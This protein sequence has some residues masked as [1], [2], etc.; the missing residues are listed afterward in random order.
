MAD[1]YPEDVDY[2]EED[3]WNEAVERGEWGEEDFDC[4]EDD[5]RF[6][7]DP[8]EYVA[9]DEELNLLGDLMCDDEPLDY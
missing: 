2:S 9:S 8:G 3:Q 6:D 4:G 7:C 1:Y 5:P